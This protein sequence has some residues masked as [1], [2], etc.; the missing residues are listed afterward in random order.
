MKI[1]LQ[2]EANTISDRELANNQRYLINLLEKI[3]LGLNLK[4]RV[5]STNKKVTP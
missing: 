3:G 1:L 4:R 2:P 5:T